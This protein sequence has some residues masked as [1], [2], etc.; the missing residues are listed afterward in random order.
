MKRILIVT[1]VMKKGVGISEF[2]N[3]VYGQLE[4]FDD[5]ELDILVEHDVNDFK[6]EFDN[7]T[8]LKSPSLKTKPLKYIKFWKNI[9][10]KGNYDYVHFHVD[11]LVRFIPFVLAKDDKKKLI[12]HSHNGSNSFVKKSIIKTVIHNT[13]RKWLTNKNIIRFSCS[14]KAAKWLFLDSE[15]TQINNG[16]K[17]SNFKFSQEI[18]NQLINELKL[19]NN[20]DIYGHVG[21]FE[22]QKNHD[23]L[24]EIFYQVVKENTNSILILI[25][26]G[27]LRDKIKNK[28]NELNIKNNVLFIDYSSDIAKYYNVFDNI[29][30][31]SRYEGFP[32]TLVEA[33]A[34]GVQVFYSDTITSDV[35]LLE[36]TKSIKINHSPKDIVS[37]MRN[38][39]IN[40]TDK[41]RS[42]CN[43]VL[44]SLGYDESDTIN[45]LYN[46]YGNKTS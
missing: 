35:E 4:K 11:N 29:I 39:S 14:D 31:P 43:N 38:N 33:Q 19:P 41:E 6:N 42:N 16:I 27:S 37:Y 3:K 9:Y 40:L 24:I 26:E 21:R 15:Y 20:V 17:L 30:F 8:F 34:N 18:R 28:V 1:T 32:I 45:F 13:V 2:I 10:S 23:K 44:I 7:I 36:Y 5:I 46:F 22:Y 12:I 25:G